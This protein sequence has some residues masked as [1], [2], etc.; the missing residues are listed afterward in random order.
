LRAGIGVV[1]QEFR[2]VANLTV[3]DNVLLGSGRRPSADIGRRVGQLA[4]EAGFDLPFG[5]RVHRLAIAHRQQVEIL[6]LLFRDLDVLIFDEPTAVLGEAQVGELFEVL[7]TLR[8]QGKAI[9]IITHRLREV[10]MIADRLTILREGVIKAADRVPEAFTD[11]ALAELMVGADRGEAAAA[12]ADRFVGDIVLRAAGVHVASASGSGL[13][14]VD[15]EVRAGEVVGVAGVRGNGQRE[16]A[17]V[18]SGLIRPEAGVIERKPGAVGF[19]PEDRLGMGLARRMTVAEN[20]VLRRYRTAPIGR[21]WLLDR[22]ALREWGARQIAAYDIPAAPDWTV[23]R[24]S[25]G[26]LQ[27]VVVARELERDA[28]VIV[29]AQPT[30][31]LD[32]RSAEFVRRRLLEAAGRGAGVLLVSE[33]LDELIEISDRILVFYEGAVVA[34]VARAAFARRTLSAM[35]LGAQRAA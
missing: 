33:D 19:I 15:L 6:K 13:R 16:I 14:G 22:A 2:L 26:G 17:E 1:H 31:G 21:A 32:I 25:G 18:A 28:P 29:A 23:T 5:E 34:S 11:A 35:M 8:R 24:L 20:L 3:L 30:R 10:R 4:R 27:R 9:L 7:R 12:R